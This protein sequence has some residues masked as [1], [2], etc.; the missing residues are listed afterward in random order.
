MRSLDSVIAWLAAASPWLWFLLAC[1]LLL[2]VYLRYFFLVL[3][4]CVGSALVPEA[5]R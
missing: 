4:A 2:P 3:G 5:P 1:A